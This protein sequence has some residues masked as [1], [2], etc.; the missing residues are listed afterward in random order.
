LIERGLV[1]AAD[2]ADRFALTCFQGE[3]LHD[4]GIMPEAGAAFAAAL[5][6]APDDGAR[7][8]AWLG[9]AAV[10]RVTE[11]L[12]GAFADLER[13]EAAAR[14]LGLNGQLA[15][16]HFLRGN[17]HFPRGEIESC[18]EQHQKSLEF[19]QAA[20]SAELEAAALGGLGD[21]QYARGRMLTARR[22]FE[23]CIALCRQHG[24]GR[25]EVASLPMVAITRFFAGELTEA[26]ADALAAVAAAER[27]GH[28][29]AAVIG[30]HIVFFA[31][32]SRGDLGAARQHVDKAIELSRHLGARRFEAE[33]LWCLAELQLAEG[34]RE[35]AVVTVRQALE[36]SRAT[37]M[38]FLG[39]ALLGRVA[40][41]TTDPEERRAALAEGELLLAAGSISHNHIW[42]YQEAVESAI[43]QRDWQAAERYADALAD[44]TRSEPLPYI[45]CCVARAKAL[46]AFGRGQ[47]DRTLQD[48]LQR[49]RASAEALGW[50]SL[51]PELERTLAAAGP[52]PDA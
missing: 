47:R 23:R 20:G 44:Y 32:M 25:I 50:R 3:I 17:L 38:G 34:R 14:R 10:K 39:P 43:E 13:A 12:E 7:C 33:G 8:R 9:L 19:A 11:D 4:L 35:D 24:F 6:A 52:V 5:E 31:A 30:G 37:G 49:V 2:P 41:T 16:I 21:V 51:L 27:V 18:L 22:H 48:A 28:H 1:L 42:F 36:I 15:R 26:Y 45:D 40:R 29:R 46:I